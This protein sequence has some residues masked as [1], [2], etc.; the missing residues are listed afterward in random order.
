MEIH[1]FVVSA[2]PG[3]AITGAALEYRKLLRQVGPSEIFASLRDPDM[4]KEVHSLEAYENLASADTGT[5]LL[6][7][8]LSIG[9]ATF[10]RFLADRNERMVAVYHNITPA[11]FFAPYDRHF[12]RLLAL[13]REQ[14]EHLR[15]RVSLALAD[16]E[17]NAEELRALGYP[18]VHV[19]PLV[20]DPHHLRG[21][22]A[23]G[24]VTAELEARPGPSLVYVGQLL[25][26]K[27]VDLLIEAFDVLATKLIPE[28]SLDLVGPARLP[29]YETVIRALVRELNLPNLHIAGSV[30]AGALASYYRGATAFVTASDHEGLCLPVLEAMAFDLPVIARGTAALP[31]TIGTGG[32]VLPA[33]A[34][35]VLLAEAMAAVLESAPLRSELV[36]AGR[37]RLSTGFDA[38]AARASFLAAILEAA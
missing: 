36:A 13:G 9:D 38:D 19:V 34:D 15:G 23:D 35:P 20:V 29:A 14:L 26:H 25:P 28:A 16:S 10:G 8:H 24:A 12:E 32:L 5:N 33:D 11:H 37:D 22:T 27:R 17:F 18:E 7:V 21:I 1:Q 30:S 3:D 4:Y 2:V 31:E 6:I